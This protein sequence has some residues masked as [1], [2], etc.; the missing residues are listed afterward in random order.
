MFIFG[1]G[2]AFATPTGAAAAGNPSPLQLGVLQETQIDISNNQ[3]DL[4]GK[5]QF[6]VAIART[7]GKITIKFKFANQFAKLW[8][9]LF[10]GA[11]VVSGEE[12]GVPDSVQAVVTHACTITPPGGGTFARNL[13]VRNGTTGQQMT[14][15]AS[16]P[17]AGISY[18]VSGGTYTFNASETATTMFISYTYTLATGFKSNVTNLP[19]GSQPVLDVTVMNSQYAN[20]DGAVNTL[21]RFPACIASK[22]TFPFKNEDFAITEFDCSALQDVNGNVMYINAD[23]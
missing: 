21:L 23:E 13:G 6:P 20:L 15:V 3:K 10:F 7:A 2:T 9:D 16:S 12:I 14:L 19:M 17:A 22:Y 8:N 18:T 1:S 4:M 5:N 11:T